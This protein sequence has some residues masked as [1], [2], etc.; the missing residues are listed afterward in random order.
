MNEKKNLVSIIV[1]CHNGEKFLNDALTSVINQSYRN[2]EL[3]FCDNQSTDKSKKIFESFENKK[4]KY[5][6]T[7]KFLNLY[8]ARNFA[9][10]KS[11]GKFIS[12]IDTDDIWEKN[13]LKRQLVLFKNPKV[14]VVYGNLYIQKEKRKKI[15]INH[16]I[17]EG[18]IYKDLIK[19]YNVGI[20]TA[21]IKKKILSKEKLIFNN[22][23][24]IIGDF[25][26]FLKLS[27]KYIFKA[28]QNP[29]ATYRIH[30]NNLSI[31]KKSIAIK[32][33][34]NWFNKNKKNL[35]SKEK[36]YIVKHIKNLEFVSIKSQKN[37]LKLLKFFYNN[38]NNLLSIKN[39]IILIF[40]IFFLKKVMW[41]L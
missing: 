16:Y 3:I 26:L 6:K 28:V 10:S 24:N 17:R 30:N 12:F 41:F 27:K 22:K 23:Y 33:F 36:K 18:Y 15:Y 31:K 1:N 5:I 19:N 35:H 7:N 14:A 21:V 4:F 20:L 29:V 32:E 37:F 8:A 34:K 9:I 38:S 39:I 40:P 13:K 11:S 2:W 25:D